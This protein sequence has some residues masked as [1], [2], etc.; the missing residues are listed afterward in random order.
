MLHLCDSR[1]G[2]TASDAQLLAS[3]ARAATTRAEAGASPFLYVVVLTKVD[4]CKPKD[5]S[6]T[7][8]AVQEGALALREALDNS[9]APL[10]LPVPVL[11]ASV[12]KRQG[13]IELWQ[14]IAAAV[15]H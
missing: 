5:C 11:K 10:P 15:A 14:R 2:L 9:D 13:G 6:K 1:H 7:E 4:R 3:A 12:L 8:R